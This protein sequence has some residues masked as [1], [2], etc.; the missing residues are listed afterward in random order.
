MCV[1]RQLLV[2]PRGFP[3]KL[4]STDASHTDTADIDKALTP[5]DPEHSLFS[6]QFSE[7]NTE[8]SDGRLFGLQLVAP[9]S[10]E[11]RGH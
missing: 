6:I 1:A 11:Y 9:G 5:D 10:F 4:E 3:K 2:D 8:A 7:F